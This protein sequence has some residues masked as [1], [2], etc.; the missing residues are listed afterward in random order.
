VTR[1]RQIILFL[2]VIFVIYA[3]YTSP[4][5]SADAVHAAWNVLTT[6]VAHV[7]D[8]FNALLTR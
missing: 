7:F 5:R 6:A 2:V 8:F 4:D 3:I 1:T